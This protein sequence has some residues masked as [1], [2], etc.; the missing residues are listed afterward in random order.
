LASLDAR[1]ET[2]DKRVQLFK[3]RRQRHESLAASGHITLAKLDDLRE[4]ALVLDSERQAL[5]ARRIRYLADQAGMESE[6]ARLPEE[7]ANSMDRLRLQL[8]DLSQ[9]IARLRGNRAY[10]VQAPLSGQVNNIGLQPGQK[11]RY[12]SPLLTLTPS[13]ATLVARLLVPV[14]A[15]GFIERG[16]ALAIR[17]DAFPYQKYGLQPG[18]IIGVAASA[19]L[20]TDNTLLPLSLNEPAF[21]VTARPENTTIQA[22]GGRIVLKP[23]MTFSADVMLERRS[24]LQWLLE[25]LY[26]LR[27]RLR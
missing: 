1:L 3:R 14:D 16:Q 18:W 11:A 12:D 17:Y 10:V 6:L 9:E 4:Q 20:P 2:L 27:G 25:P 8:S 5:A 26:S 24:L 7:A 21:R 22:H 23:G 13:G 19:T 15:A